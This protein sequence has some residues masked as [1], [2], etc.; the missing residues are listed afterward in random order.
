M[1][2]T[3]L[4]IVFAMSLTLPAMASELKFGFQNPGFGGNPL[5]SNYYLGML[6]NQKLPKEDRD[7]PLSEDN[8]VKDFADG[9][10][11]RILSA[12]ASKITQD[13]FGSDNTQGNFTIDNMLLN[14]Q[15]VGDKVVINLTDG[16]TSTTI[17]VPRFDVENGT[18]S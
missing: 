14:Y 12:V 5:A 3:T 1:R 11:S 17:T 15:V 2:G 13:I 16:I 7:D 18:G 4:A 6:E 8:L 10:K 9:L